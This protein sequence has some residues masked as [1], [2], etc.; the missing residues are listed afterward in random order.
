MNFFKAIANIREIFFPMF[1]WAFMFAIYWGFSWFFNEPVTPL[2]YLM[3]VFLALAIYIAYRLQG[4]TNYDKPFRLDKNKNFFIMALLGTL[5]VVFI[6]YKNLGN[7]GRDLADVREEHLE[8]AI[9]GGLEDTLY[10]IFFPLLIISFIVVNFNNLKYKI[11]INCFVIFSCVAF[12]PINGGR[13]NFLVFGALYGAIALFKNFESIRKKKIKNLLKFVLYFIVACVLGSFYG[14]ARTGKDNDQ[15]VGYLYTLKY[16]NKDVLIALLKVPYNAG[17][18]LIL[19]ITAFYD[20]TGGNVYYLGI[21]IDNFHKIDYRTYGFYNFIFLDRFQII[22][23]NKAHEDIDKLYLPYDIVQNVWATAIRDFAIDFGLIGTFI[24][25]ML[26]CSLMF[27]ARK[28]LHRSYSA[29]VI[30]FL[31]FAFLLFSPFHSLFF[32]TRVYGITLL[33]AIIGF[34]RFKFAPKT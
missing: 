3:P 20:Y 21:F 16:V 7:L 13:I 34:L 10:S 2:V 23:A 32:L 22:D 33:I 12:I 24:A 4:Y 5:T 25:I 6:F 19:F 14:I 8:N 9:N 27:N 26:L 30:F 18:I 11:L 28:Y 1:L 29:Q 17:L 15:I 31:L